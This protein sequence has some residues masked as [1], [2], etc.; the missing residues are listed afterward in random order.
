MF[1]CSFPQYPKSMANMSMVLG[2][3]VHPEY[4][5]AQPKMTY[6]IKSGGVEESLYLMPL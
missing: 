5:F 4:I 6:P 1:E 3:P 2:S